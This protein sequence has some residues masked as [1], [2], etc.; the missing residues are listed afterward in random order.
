MEHVGLRA[1]IHQQTGRRLIF[2]DCSNAFNTVNR[3]EVCALGLARLTVCSQVL[4][5]KSV[6]RLLPDGLR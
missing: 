3:A 5:T 6:R 2:L 4:W 1:K